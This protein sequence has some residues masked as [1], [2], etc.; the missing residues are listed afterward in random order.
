LATL[1]HGLFAFGWIA[2]VPLFWSLHGL[3]PRARF[4]Q[5]WLCG[6]LSFALL[7][8]WVA[9]AITR[10]S[11]MIGVPSFF[12]A[13]LGVVAVGLIAL[14]HGS[15]VAVTAWVWNPSVTRWPL[16]WPLLIA[17][18]WTALDVVRCSSPLAHSWGALAYTQWRDTALLQSVSVIGQHGLT[19]LCV[20]FAASVA[21]WLRRASEDRRAVQ[22]CVAPVVVFVFLH[23][24][25][26]WQLSKVETPG[27]S[28]NVLVVQT[29]AGSGSS[30]LQNAFAQAL[31]LTQEAVRVQQSQSAPP[32][33]L[34]VWPETTLGLMRS[35]P[36]SP[37]N[38]YSIGRDIDAWE[39]RSLVELSRQAGAPVLF[40]ANVLEANGSRSNEAMLINGQ[41][42]VQTQAKMH[43]VPFGERA[44]FE[45]MLPLLRSLAPQPAMVPGHEV[46]PLL[47]EH[48]TLGSVAVGT[49]ICFESCFAQPARSLKAAGAQLFVVLTNDEWFAGSEAPWQHT[50]M[51]AVRA[52][53]NN[54]W[55]V[56]SANGGYCFAVDPQGRFVV[57]SNFNVP[58]TM[59][60]QIPLRPSS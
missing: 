60:M 38:E 55:V 36:P 9:L 3:S 56:Q 53:E 28:L 17:L 5:G 25:G 8:W 24:W 16:L 57:K 14:V 41:G 7:N 11:H 23:G 31:E 12:G 40:G 20:W 29:T 18:C 4:R 44:P 39:L 26:T 19:F 43:L 37:K 2:L 47:L 50:A 6:F 10:G 27:A 33:D 59:R 30:K 32:F 52:V 58:L 49:L 22:L 35:V 21:L 51:S 42:E 46:Q 45:E 13:G 48:R 34:I 15:L 1:Q 54:A